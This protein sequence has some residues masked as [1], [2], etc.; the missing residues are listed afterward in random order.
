MDIFSQMYVQETINIFY[1]CE[2]KE[3]T[4]NCHIACIQRSKPT[5]DISY[6]SKFHLIG[7]P[8]TT[9]GVYLDEF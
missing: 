8:S 5:N 7:H 1:N 2:V 9:P 6:S 3:E 4:G